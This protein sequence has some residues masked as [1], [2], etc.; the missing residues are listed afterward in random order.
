MKE[1]KPLQMARQKDTSLRLYIETCQVKITSLEQKI[2]SFR[3]LV[4][5]DQCL[6][7]QYIIFYPVYVSGSRYSR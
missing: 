6:F 5:I 4:V 7:L 2:Y 3:Y 1:K